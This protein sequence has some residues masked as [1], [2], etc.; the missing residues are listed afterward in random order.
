[1][2]NVTIRVEPLILLIGLTR[3]RRPVS[4]L[5]DETPPLFGEVD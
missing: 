5:L 3:N 1:M 2:M 4:R